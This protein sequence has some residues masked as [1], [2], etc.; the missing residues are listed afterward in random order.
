MPMKKRSLEQEKKKTTK[1]DITDKGDEQET[2]KGDEQEPD[3]G[4]EQETEKQPEEK[5]GDTDDQEEVLSEGD[6]EVPG[7]ETASDFHKERISHV[8]LNKP[9]GCDVVQPFMKHPTLIKFW[10]VQPQ[11]EIVQLRAALENKEKA[12]YKEGAN[13]KK[14]SK[15]F[16]LLRNIGFGGPAKFAKATFGKTVPAWVMAVCHLDMS[17]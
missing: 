14:R 7:I 13:F 2:E 11:E 1:E 8:Q 10:T 4:D 3:E 17:L 12:D 9:V 16:E 5:D 15:L 6:L